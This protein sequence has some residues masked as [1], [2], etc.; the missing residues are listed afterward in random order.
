MVLTKTEAQAERGQ[1]GARGRPE[2]EGGG[3]EVLH[4]R[5]L[6]GPG[7]QAPG[8]GQG[9]AGEGAGHRDL[10]RQ[11]GRGRGSGQDPV[12]LVRVRG[13]RRSRPPRS[14]RSRRPRRRSRT[15]SARSASRRRWTSSSR[16]SASS[17][18]TT[19][20]APTTTGWR[21]ARTLRRRRPTPVR[22]PAASSPSRSSPRQPQQPQ[23]RRSPPGA[24]EL[25]PARRGSPGRARCGSTRS[26]GGCGASAPGTAS[27][28]SAR[29]CR[30]RS[31]RPTSWRT[32]P[33]AGDDAQ[34]LDELGDVL[35]QVYFLALLL[36]ERGQG[37][38]AAVAEH[39]REKLI[40]RHP[41][42]FGER[43]AETAATWCATGP[44][45][46]A[47]EERG[48]EIF[49]HMPETLPSTIYAKQGAAPRRERG[50][51]ASAPLPGARR[52]PR[53]CDSML[54]SGDQCF[55]QLGSCS[56]TW[57]PRRAPAAS[58]RSWR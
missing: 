4:R 31:R 6:Q 52:C 19:P 15:C 14:S 34:L 24:A 32:P 8:R 13:R 41:H 16:T 56:G 7:R 44:R 47:S 12:R 26:P 33:T 9:P 43:A 55:A 11:E 21:S 37:D 5:G 50:L 42:V 39:C 2:L 22:P 54:E 25:V 20:T 53:A 36:E 58:I 1:A 3:Q 38:L 18:R 28:T 46:S 40:R 49:G 23:P 30:T 48:G 29:S 51:E 10:R 17:T 45:S 35:F 27:R 57:W